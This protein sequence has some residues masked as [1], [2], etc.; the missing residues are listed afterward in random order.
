MDRIDVMRLFLRVADT[1]NFSKVARESAISQPTVSKLIA[2]LELKL[3]A[4]L[5]RRTSRGLNLTDAGQDF[6]EAASGI[7]QSVDDVE[8]RVGKGEASPAGLVRVALSPAFGRMQVVPRLP[9]FFARYP[10]VSVDFDVSQRYVNLVEDGLDLAIRMGTLSDSTLMARRIGSM[11]Y[12][13]VAAPA[14]LER[15]GVP[16]TPGELK[17]HRCIAFMAKDAPRPWQFQGEAGPL[18]HLP[19]GSLRSNDA[20]YIRAGVLAG[21]GIAHNAG[22]LYAR[23][24]D[25][26]RLVPLLQAH[27]PAPFPIHAVWPGSRRLPARTRVFIEFLAELFAENPLLKIR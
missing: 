20:E 2:G 21:L 14:Y 10:D 11:A 16:Q 19:Q 23:D 24:I 9:E 13:T 22:W 17:E 5:L 12:M 8:A 6:Y 3:G 4:Q 15:A 7:V 25:E 27:A 26:G 1:G 18:E